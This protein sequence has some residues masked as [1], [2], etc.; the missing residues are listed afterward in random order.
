[1]RWKVICLH[2]FFTPFA[3]NQTSTFTQYLLWFTIQVFVTTSLRFVAPLAYWGWVMY[4]FSHPWGW[5]SKLLS[6]N[7]GVG[8]VFFLSNPFFKSSGPPPL[9]FDHSLTFLPRVFRALIW[10][11]EKIAYQGC[12]ST[13]KNFESHII[14]RVSKESMS[15]SGWRS[16]PTEH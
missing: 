16:P 9:L 15:W 6:R 11:A 1:M 4:I 7:A 13:Q 3:W 12:Q 2:L 14:W 10:W 5:I 8:N